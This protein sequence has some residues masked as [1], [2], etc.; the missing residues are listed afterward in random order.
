MG[1]FQGHHAPPDV[2]AEQI[3]SRDL[4]KLIRKLR[5]IGMETEA[6]ELQAKL[7]DVSA[8]KRDGYVAA[9]QGTD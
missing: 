4:A 8:D 9:A 6:R 7:N 2:G 3:D 5:G 1:L